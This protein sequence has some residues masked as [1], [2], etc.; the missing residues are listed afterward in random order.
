ML[1]SASLLD[2]KLLEQ[3]RDSC[4]KVGSVLLIVLSESAHILVM[5]DSCEEFLNK[6]RKTQTK[7][8]TSER[9]A[10]LILTNLLFDLM[11]KL[12]QAGAC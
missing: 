4:L 8:R 1:K 9:G 3:I 7:E 12:I 5:S 11:K 10:A 6:V 2:P